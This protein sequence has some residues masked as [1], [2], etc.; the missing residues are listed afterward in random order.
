MAARAPSPAARGLRSADRNSR[1]RPAP[2]AGA[3]LAAA[4]AAAAGGG[5]RE[6]PAEGLADPSRRPC[7][8]RGPITGLHTPADGELTTSQ[9]T[10]PAYD[11]PWYPGS[12]LAR[13]S[14]G[15]QRVS[16]IPE[17]EAAIVGQATQRT[18]HAAHPKAGQDMKS[19]SLS[20]QAFCLPH[21]TLRTSRPVSSSY[22]QRN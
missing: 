22:T 21:P 10:A 14:R 13:H 9:G 12:L 17:T 16:G 4:A 20:H 7:R 3:A 11:S 8:R 6:G 5:R 15:D 1:P 18:S 2:P 19:S